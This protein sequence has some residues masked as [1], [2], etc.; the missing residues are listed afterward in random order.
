M[1]YINIDIRL[2]D[3][4]ELN[5]IDIILYSF[6]N[7]YTKKDIPCIYSNSRLAMILNTSER[8][9]TR[10]VKKLIDLD[11]LTVKKSNRGHNTLIR[12]T[13]PYKNNKI[14]NPWLNKTEEEINETNRIIKELKKKWRRS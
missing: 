1:E 12:T 6:F 7:G 5:Y 4:K 11:L 2:F 8:S 10:S 3:Y 14:L 13:K 9:I